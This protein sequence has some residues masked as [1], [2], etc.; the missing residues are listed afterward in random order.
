[1]SDNTFNNPLLGV[2]VGS[3]LQS[4]QDGFTASAITGNITQMIPQVESN[5]FMTG[6]SSHIYSSSMNRGTLG[7]SGS[8]GLSAVSQINSSLYGYMGNA[9]AKDGTETRIDYNVIMQC[10][11]EYIDFDQLLPSDFIASLK[12]AQKN[13]ALTALL[14][15]K[16]LLDPKLSDD[17]RVQKLTEWTAAREQFF[18][19]AGHGVVVGILWG[20]VGSISLSITQSS[21]S[22]N[23]QYGGQANFS[24]VGLALTASVAATYDGSSSAA[25]SDVSIQILRYYSGSIISNDI[26]SWYSN[27]AKEA[28]DKLLNSTVV[29]SPSFPQG[30]L[31]PPSIP[32]FTKPE[33]DN[34]LKEN[35]EGLKSLHDLDRMSK[36]AQ[37]QTE[38]KT[39][40]DLSRADFDK[41]VNP[42]TKAD[43]TKLTEL[44]E[45][46]HSNSLGLP[47]EFFEFALNQERNYVE[48]VSMVDSS[49]SSTQASSIDYSQY[50]PLGVWIANWSD[51]LPWLSTAALNSIPSV[52]ET[53]N[54]LYFQVVI[55]DFDALR[56]IYYQ[57]HYCNLSLDDI[58]FLSIADSY[59][60][61]LAQ[62]STST[63]KSNN[64]MRINIQNAI[65]GLSDKA[66]AI[67]K[68]WNEIS[69]LRG[70]ELGLG[71]VF[72]EKYS[73]SFE[74]SLSQEYFEEIYVPLAGTFKRPFVLEPDTIFI[75]KNTDFDSAVGNYSAFSQ[76]MKCVPLVH[77]SGKIYLLGPGIGGNIAAMHSSVQG[78]PGVNIGGTNP[79]ILFS[80]NGNVREFTGF[81]AQGKAILGKERN[82]FALLEFEPDSTNNILKNTDAKIKAY[83]IPFAAAKGISWKG[84]SI[85][86]NIAS[87]EDLNDKLLHFHDLLKDLSAWT[88]SSSSWDQDWTGSTSY[89]L[90]KIKTQYVGIVPESG[91]IFAKE[92]N[93]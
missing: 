36:D 71:I 53:K 70:C 23:W 15:Y 33:Q 92:H 22:S 8:Y 64:E 60:N 72:D 42:E 85:S 29:D 35:I 66:R 12:M 34:N 76:L 28:T 79:Y 44:A 82:D 86:R 31:E 58:D 93:E 37:F 62:L 26:E 56:K 43:V 69:F 27:L 41:E 1:M 83:P 25:G 51:L 73:L 89:A 77:P 18:E 74:H 75:F 54:L 59:S 67:Y 9:S 91:N 48:M 68:R 16:A 30:P 4:L 87:F 90:E 45:E 63:F 14:A 3:C 80:S 57:A 2:T 40:Q 21:T 61:Q 65:R 88:F 19:I 7:I 17:D 11:V 39:R 5:A 6:T 46:V 50:V 38:S 52:D 55:Q 84:E 78:S 49:S 13:S 81:D 24:Y 47:E 10:G 32:A 20:A